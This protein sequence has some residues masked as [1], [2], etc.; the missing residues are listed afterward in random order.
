VNRGRFTLEPNPPVAGSPVK[1]TYTGTSETVEWSVDGGS[2]HKQTVPP[3]TFNID[4]PEG[5]TLFLTD[6]DAQVG[7]VEGFLIDRAL[8]SDAR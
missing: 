8:R 5:T 7:S 4:V 1:V 6:P 2:D 3:K